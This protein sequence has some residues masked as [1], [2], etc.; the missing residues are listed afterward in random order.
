LFEDAA[1]LTLNFVAA[2][3]REDQGLKTMLGGALGFLGEALTAQHL[4]QATIQ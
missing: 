3:C 1:A 4:P 2:I